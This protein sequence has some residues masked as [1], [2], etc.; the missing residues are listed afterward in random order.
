MKVVLSAAAKADLIEIGDYIAA[1][2]C[3][4]ARTFVDELVACCR[5]LATMP[6]AFP[7]VMP[8]KAAGVRRRPYR[9]CVI[10]YRIEGETVQ[11]LHV[12]HGARD[13]DWLLFPE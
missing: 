12:L 2:S 5:Q 8:E 1:G 11:V 4:R 7:L 6:R 9:D 3:Q 13:Q 10:F